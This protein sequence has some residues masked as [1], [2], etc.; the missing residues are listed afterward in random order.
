MCH[1]RED[2]GVTEPRV[3]SCEG[4][5]TNF[6]D[7]ADEHQDTLSDEMLAHMLQLQ[8]DQEY[9]RELGKEEAKFNGSSKGLFLF[10]KSFLFLFHNLYVYLVAVSLSNYRKIP[11]GSLLDEDSDLS[12]EDWET[13]PKDWDSFEV[14][15]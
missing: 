12:D 7:Y 2:A 14:S 1:C 6:T 8:F 13:K 15:T 3:S 4:L 9:D 11:K 10:L 5:S